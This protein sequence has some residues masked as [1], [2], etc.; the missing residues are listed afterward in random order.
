MLLYFLVLYYW[1]QISHSNQSL[2]FLIYSSSNQAP[3]TPGPGLAAFT[4]CLFVVKAH[5]VNNFHET[6]ALPPKYAPLHR[7]RPL[8]LQPQLLLLRQDGRRV[9]DQLFRAA[10]WCQSTTRQQYTTVTVTHQT[11]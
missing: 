8:T 11:A 3:W 2:A 10:A 6:R 4:H 7:S 5:F 9:L 1:I